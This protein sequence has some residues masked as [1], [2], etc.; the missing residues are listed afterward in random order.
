M[1]RR[2]WTVN[3]ETIIEDLLRASSNKRTTGDPCTLEIA[4]KIRAAHKRRIK[5]RM[6]QAWA[7]RQAAEKR[8]P[9]TIDRYL[10]RMEPGAWYSVHEVA[11]AA[12]ENYNAA[13][14]VS[15]ALLNKRLCERLIN[16]AW[17]PHDGA[18]GRTRGP[19]PPGLRLEPKWLYRLTAIGEARQVCL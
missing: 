12:G 5:D 4:D 11:R 3:P 8:K 6:A 16:P 18:R 9:E 7:R 2:P 1:R 13:G 17:M 14:R 10:A 15:Q 19:I